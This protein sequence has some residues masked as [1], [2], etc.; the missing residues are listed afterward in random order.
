MFSVAD[1]YQVSEA[2]PGFIFTRNVC[3]NSSYALA[4]KKRGGRRQVV[5]RRIILKWS[6]KKYSVS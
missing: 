1:F 4:L 5:P 6:L 3:F 2:S